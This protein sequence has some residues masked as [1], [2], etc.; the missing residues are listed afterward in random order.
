MNVYRG[1]RGVA[2]PILNLANRSMKMVSFI[3][4]VGSRASLDEKNLLP[5]LG[6]KSQIFQ[7]VSLVTVLTVSFHKC[8]T[9][10]FYVTV[11]NTV[12]VKC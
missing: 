7:P 3:H 12:D 4:W 5:L 2:P 1:S 9:K 10:Y 8:Y 6:T 11:T